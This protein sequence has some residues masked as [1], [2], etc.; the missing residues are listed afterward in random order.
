MCG[1]GGEGRSE[2]RERHGVGN[3]NENYTTY[4]K[5]AVEGNTVTLDVDVQ[6]PAIAFN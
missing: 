6:K 2:E 1:V 3:Y 5:G 4:S